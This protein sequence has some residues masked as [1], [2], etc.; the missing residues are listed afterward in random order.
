[1]AVVVD[2]AA[3]M[4]VDVMVSYLCMTKSLFNKSINIYSPCCFCILSPMVLPW[5]VCN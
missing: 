1:M 4:Y 5:G 3:R 2:D